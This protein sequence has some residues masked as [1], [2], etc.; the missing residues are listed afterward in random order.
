M[1]VKNSNYGNGTIGYEKVGKYEYYA[2][3]YFD[4]AGKRHKKRFPHTKEGEKEAKNFQKEISRK[5]M[6]VFQ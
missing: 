1:P 2:L 5:K 3:Q 4:N 6:M